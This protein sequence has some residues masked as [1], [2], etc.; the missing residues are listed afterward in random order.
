M[1]SLMHMDIFDKNLLCNLVSG[2]TKGKKQTFQRDKDQKH[3]SNV[4]QPYMSSKIVK[5]CNWIVESSDLNGVKHLQRKLKH[6]IKKM[7]DLKGTELF[8]AVR[9]ERDKIP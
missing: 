9:K 6:R 1:D 5:G 4:D 3:N 2:K 7:K 8:K